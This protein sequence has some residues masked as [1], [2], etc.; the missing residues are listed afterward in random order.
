MR[1]VHVVLA[2][3]AGALRRRQAGERPLGGSCKRTPEM[4]IEENL[5]P[6]QSPLDVSWLLR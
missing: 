6:R 5:R 1:Q 4:E 3:I 2:R